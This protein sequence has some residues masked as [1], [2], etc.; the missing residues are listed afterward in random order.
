M[1]PQR[2][3]TCSAGGGRR[4]NSVSGTC[5][6]RW[7]QEVHPVVCTS[8]GTSKCGSTTSRSGYV[9]SDARVE[10]NRQAREEA[11]D[12]RQLEKLRVVRGV[13]PGGRD[14]RFWVSWNQKQPLTRIFTRSRRADATRTTVRRRLQLSVDSNSTSIAPVRSRTKPPQARNCPLKRSRTWRTPRP[15]SRRTRTS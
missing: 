14:K 4:Q 10:M 5:R 7:R 3:R 15:R 9:A 11:G 1:R 2:L 13:V 6:R 8:G 12:A